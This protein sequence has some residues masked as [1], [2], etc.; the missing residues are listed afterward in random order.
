MKLIY[1][2]YALGIEYIPK[3]HFEGFDLFDLFKY[4]SNVI[5]DLI[6]YIYFCI[7]KMRF[8]IAFFS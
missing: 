1:V 6:L 3:M 4:N 2:E 7:D 8:I 5:L